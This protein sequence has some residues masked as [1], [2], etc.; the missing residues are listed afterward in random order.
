MDWTTI[1]T[2]LH[3]WYFNHKRDL[4]WRKTT[5]AYTIWLSEIILQQTR[6][7]Q[8]LPY[9]NR[10]VNR[11]PKVSDLAAA[12]Q[13]EVLRMWEGLGYYSR[14]RNLHQAANAVV[15][16]HQGEFPKSYASIKRLKGIG[17]Y[18]AA[19]IASFAYNLPHAVVDGNVYRVLSRICGET[20]PINTSEGKKRFQ[21]LAD[22]LL[23]KEEPGDHNQ[24]IMEFGALQCV[25]KNPNCLDC[26]LKEACVA[27]ARAMVSELPQK[28]RKSYS[29]QRYLNYW[30]FQFE[31]GT[32]VEQRQK[33][34]W[35]A[36]HQFPLY[37]SERPLEGEELP[38]I[39]EERYQLKPN[40]Y[41]VQLW[42]LPLHKLSHQSLYISMWEIHLTKQA[43]QKLE[44][45][46]KQ[47][48]L[49]QLKEVALPRPLRKF[50]DENQ[51]TLPLD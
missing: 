33:G 4:P 39:L 17:D 21:S 46:Y 34:I 3:K 8:G 26:P 36:L 6:V 45:L 15:A 31:D 2:E 30:F 24:A 47:L 38:S 11:F 23:D 32:W 12:E 16:E 25:P 22:A 9:F 13:D 50:L 1:R 44:G 18:T 19:A 14:A 28:L 20:T 27:H 43:A 41:K 40:N 49:T 10:F 42:R 51:L 48:K 37:E 35:K 7:E 5:D 29:K